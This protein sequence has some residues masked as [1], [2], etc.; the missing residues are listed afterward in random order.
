MTAQAGGASPLRIFFSISTQ[1]ARARVVALPYPMRK[2]FACD[3]PPFILADF[4]AARS[5]HRPAVI[6]DRDELRRTMRNVR[7]NIP[8]ATR[9][10]A[11][12]RIAVLADR[13]Y[14]LKPGTRIAAYH[15]YGAEVDLTPLIQRAWQRHCSVFLPV[16]TDPRRSRMDFFRYDAETMLASNAFG[17]PEPPADPS[18][19]IVPR[20]LDV[21]FMPLVAFDVNGWRLGSGAGFYDRCLQ[22]LR[23]ARLWRRPKLIGVAYTQQQVERLE[24]CPWDVPMDGIITQDFFKRFS[25]SRSGAIPCS[26][27]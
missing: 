26:T 14:L 16:I 25:M 11:A 3:H 8:I 20:H 13:A 15:A 2:T 7:R 24:F 12:R 6:P 9:R 5:I 1:P 22:H 23:P 27:G 10:A 4:A 21:V 19:R 17:I 18:E